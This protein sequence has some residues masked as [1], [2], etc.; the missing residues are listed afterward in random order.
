M[1]LKDKKCVPCVGLTPPL[2]PE[3]KYHLLNQLRNGWKLTCE[4]K[5]I[6]RNFEFKNFKDAL[7]FTIEVGQIAE[8]ERHHPELHLGWGHCRVEIWTH[9]NSDLLEN[10]FILA[11]KITEVYSRLSGSFPS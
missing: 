1:D 8:E 9:T 10:D 2:A 4:E 3:Q 7:N 11:A 5:R 6:E